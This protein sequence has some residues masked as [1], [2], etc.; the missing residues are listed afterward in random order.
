MR[1][2]LAALLP[3]QAAVELTRDRE[4]RFAAGDRSFELFAQR[5]ACTEDERLDCARR[6]LEDLGDLSVRAP[7]ELAHHECR[8]LV[9]GEMT[10]RASDVVARR[11]GVVPDRV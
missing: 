7:L 8:P 3:R 9:E 10:E 1:A 5:T 4:L 6:D 2:Q 11:R